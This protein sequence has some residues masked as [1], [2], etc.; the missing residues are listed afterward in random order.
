MAGSCPV[1][2]E[3]DVEAK[4][5]ALNLALQATVNVGLHISHMFVNNP[6]ICRILTLNHPSSSKRLNSWIPSINQLFTM[7]GCPAMHIIPKTWAS[8]TFKLVLHTVN[9]HVLTLFF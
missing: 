8:P 5:L 9:L 1:H 7:A 3:T 6:D 2:A 4:I